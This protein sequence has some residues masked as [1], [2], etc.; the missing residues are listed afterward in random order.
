MFISRVPLN[1]ARIGARQLVG[2]PYRMHAAV[3]SAFPPGSVRDGD[4]GRILWRLDTLTQDHTVW[5]YVVSPEA[6]DFAHIIEQAGWPTHMEW[7][8]KDYS[9]L[10]SRIAVGQ[11]WQ[12]RLRANPARKALADKG[13]R[14]K[15]N[16]EGVV[17]KIQGHVTAAQ[18]RDW[19][20]SRAA[21]HGF[22]IIPDDGGD[23][24]VVVSQRHQER[25][26]REGKTI[27]LTTAVFDGQL[28]V[29]DADL[30]RRTLCHGLGRAKGFGCGLMTVAPLMVQP[31]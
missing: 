6:P 2:S 24:S 5:L 13:R 18:Q 19:L 12:F 3:E 14:P 10:L 31:E 22:A 29:T 9:P 17:G 27:T 15:A 11:R 1:M 20:V 23:P 7:E 21:A 28:E 4:D 16:G 30:F 26:G 8:S 25:F